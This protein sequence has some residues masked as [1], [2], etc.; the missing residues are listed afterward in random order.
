MRRVKKKWHECLDE[1]NY[2]VNN[3]T[4]YWIG[5]TLKYMTLWMNWSTNRMSW[6]KGMRK[7]KTE[8]GEPTLV[9]W[10]ITHISPVHLRRDVYGLMVLWFRPTI[11]MV[12]QIYRQKD[13]GGVFSQWE[14]GRRHGLSNHE[15]LVAISIFI[16]KKS[17]PVC[18]KQDN[19]INWALG[20]RNF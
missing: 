18:I 11:R 4:V 13:Y 6:I 3:E 12:A 16:G 14:M 19:Y 17:T 9:L 5:E 10:A 2:W 8:W 15:T 1:A 20:L 7:A